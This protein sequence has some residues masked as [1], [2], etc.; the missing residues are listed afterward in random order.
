[1]IK[2]FIKILI[3]IPTLIIALPFAI[4][5]WLISGNDEYFNPEDSLPY[6][7]MDW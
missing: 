4:I 5:A 7:L 1:M 6:K 3:F 2:R